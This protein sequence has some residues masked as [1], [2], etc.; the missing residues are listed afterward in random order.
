MVDRYG[1]SELV[2]CGEDYTCCI[3]KGLEDQLWPRV[4]SKLVALLSPKRFTNWF[5]RG[6]VRRRRISQ[7]VSGNKFFLT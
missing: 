2:V 4:K 1:W 3:R 5:W 7:K 6:Q